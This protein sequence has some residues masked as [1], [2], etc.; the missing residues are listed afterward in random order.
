MLASQL[1]QTL[2]DF[3]IGDYNDLYVQLGLVLVP[4]DDEAVRGMQQ[5]LSN[6]STPGL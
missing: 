5:P 4:T 3:L 1:A 2:V 6:I